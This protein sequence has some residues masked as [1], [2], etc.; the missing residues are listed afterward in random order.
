LPSLKAGESSDRYRTPPVNDYQR[1]LRRGA[2]EQLT[3]HVAS[4]HPPET[5]R[6]IA[7]TPPGKPL[8]S[9]FRQRVRL[10]PRKPSPTLVAGGIRPQFHHGHP[11]DARGLSIRERSRLM[12]IPDSY[13]IRGGIV[14]GRVQ[15]GQAVPPL[16]GRAIG[17]AIL[18]SLTESRFRRDLL[19]WSRDHSRNFPWR[20]G[21][22]DPFLILVAEI[23]LRKTRA[24]SVAREWDSIIKLCGSPEE[25]LRHS[26]AEWESALRPLGLA[27]T[28]TRV[29]REISRELLVRHMGSVPSSPE[30]LARV[31]GIGPYIANATIA[32]AYDVKLPVLD[33]NVHRV[34]VRVFGMW[35]AQELHKAPHLWAAAREILPEKGHRQLT[36]ALLDFGAS[37]CMATPKC[38]A[39]FAR[40]YCHFYV[41]TNGTLSEKLW[42]PA[43]PNGPTDRA[44]FREVPKHGQGEA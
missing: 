38:V 18:L 13:L 44:G 20:G 34:L 11:W 32:F 29:I 8:Y 33:V 21:K 28:R 26:E 10:D 31:P 3:N 1:F 37:V 6:R 23:L 41:T 24:E 5:V 9:S 25:A 19:D 16:L 42:N 43:G 30:L 14:M 27:K 2:P 35:P 15:T 7:S 36:L 17:T 4:S 22:T 39:C 40:E 12:S